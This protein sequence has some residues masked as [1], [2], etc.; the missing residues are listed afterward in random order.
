MRNGA[1]TIGRITC[2]SAPFDMRGTTFV[3]GPVFSWNGNDTV[4]P[5]KHAPLM[6]VGQPYDGLAISDW[7]A[8]LCRNC[9]AC[10]SNVMLKSV[11]NANV[12]WLMIGIRYSRFAVKLVSPPTDDSRYTGNGIW[13]APRF[14]LVGSRGTVVPSGFVRL[15][16]TLVGMNV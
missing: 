12:T 13:I 7:P 10:A 5:P 14:G 9:P 6:N 15:N 11:N 1:F 3:P 4:F 16:I 2:N 8:G